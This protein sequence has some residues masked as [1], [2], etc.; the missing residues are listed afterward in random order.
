MTRQE[1]LDFLAEGFAVYTTGVRRETNP[2]PI[3]S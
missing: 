1:L 2:P 3:C